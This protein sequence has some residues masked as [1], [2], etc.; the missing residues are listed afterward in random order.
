M[1]TVGGIF[2][3]GTGFTSEKKKKEGTYKIKNTSYIKFK[4][5][6]IGCIVEQ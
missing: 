4:L 1:D 5:R 6:T 2:Y 3:V